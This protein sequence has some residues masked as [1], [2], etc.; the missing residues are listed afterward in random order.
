MPV[1]NTRIHL[2]I[3]WAAASALIAFRLF[4]A[5]CN[6]VW[7]DPDALADDI[8][9]LN[10]ANIFEHFSVWNTFSMA[11]TMSFPVFLGFIHILGIPYNLAAG[12]LWVIGAFFTLWFFSHYI[13]NIYGRLIVFAFMLYCPAAF[14]IWTG[15]RIYRQAIVAPTALIAIM[16]IF[17]LVT[18]LCI[19]GAG[20]NEKSAFRIIIILSILAGLSFLF[21]YYVKE[22]SIWLAPL[23][24]IASTM[25]VFVIVRRRPERR[26][27]IKLVFFALLPLILFA[28]GTNAYKAVNYHYFGVFEINTRTGGE[29]GEFAGKLL[30]IEDGNKTDEVW[31]PYST[32]E[33]AFQASPT[34]SGAPGLLES[35]RRQ[36]IYADG[37]MVENPIP[38]DLVF[39]AFKVS[40]EEAGLYGS[41][42]QAEMFF[43]EANRELDAAFRDGRLAKREGIAI[44]RSIPR[45]TPDEIA[46]LWPLAREIFLY[47]AM[48]QWS[49]TKI[50]LIEHER[51]STVESAL[52]VDIP[53]DWPDLTAANY[54]SFAVSNGVIDIYRR[55][56]PFLLLMSLAGFLCWLLDRLRLKRQRRGDGQH[57]QEDQAQDACIHQLSPV[58]AATIVLSGII[59]IA[60]VCWFIEW[61]Y[62]GYH[63]QDIS[64]TAS[65]VLNYYSC[66]AA[67]LFMLLEISGISYL[68]SVVFKAIRFPRRHS[69]S[70]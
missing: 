53:S 26:T 55:A 46:A 49:S 34:L 65:T 27:C 68:L 2:K 66:G 22:D 62:L 1:A 10:Y 32:L 3:F 69:H 58:F 57:K 61:L 54:A 63:R 18:K 5:V 44:T 14:D 13:N 56:A 70:A 6:P 36:E 7:I 20:T 15:L 41:E 39:W 11:K 59:L 40:L 29:F 30:Q 35:L 64:Y 19:Y 33:K 47:Q 60:G 37:D 4:L 67:P 28:G 42:V 43:R 9:M 21:F 17:L 45:R 12:A 16:C 50:H 24:V 38:G 8:L 48:W 25:G 52:H 23:Y 51:L 31:V